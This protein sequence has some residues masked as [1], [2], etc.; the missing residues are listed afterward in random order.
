MGWFIHHV[1]LQAHDVI[2]AAAFYREIIGL[3]DGVWAYPETVGYVGHDPETI[4]AFG[5]ENR[6][7]HLCRAIPE[8][9]LRNNF[10]HNPTIG[11]HFAINTFD[12]DAVK[13]RL[14][15]AGHIVSEAGVYAMAGIRQ[16][17]AY[18]PFQNVIEVNETVDKSGGASPSEDEAHDVRLEEGDWYLHH[19]QIPAH[20]VGK[21]A[22][23]FR[24]VIGLP[25]GEWGTP[26][27]SDVAPSEH[28]QFAF[29]GKDHRGIH[30]VK[31]SAAAGR[32]AGFHHNPTVGP[33]MALGVSDLDAVKRRLE[34]AA[35][36]YTD[37]G[38]DSATGLRRIY[39]YDPSMN[40]IEV[41]QKAA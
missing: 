25:E 31:P 9:P 6:G 21:T 34:D 5:S 35:V 13:A 38:L 14:E 23:Y 36:V 24:D 22:A 11:G 41:N 40:L 19:V 26:D 7:I 32:Q 16:I 1:N 3:R 12:V 37:A 8:F 28:G 2:E 10:F 33:C 18:D 29:F 27:G 20:D 39:C 15:Q 30:I 4:A 17:Y